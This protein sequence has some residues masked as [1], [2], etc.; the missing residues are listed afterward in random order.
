LDVSQDCSAVLL[1][2]C[3]EGPIAALRAGA[4]GAFAADFTWTWQGA[5]PSGGSDPATLSGTLIRGVVDGTLTW[6]SASQTV[7]AV[8]GVAPGTGL[9][10]A[11]CPLD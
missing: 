2:Y 3:G 7:Q 9:G 4:D 11:N 10:V 6:A 1:G 8:L 5:G